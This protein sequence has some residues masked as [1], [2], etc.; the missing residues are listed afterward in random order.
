LTDAVPL[1][2]DGV[3]E[4]ADAVICTSPDS[5]LNTDFQNNSPHPGNIEAESLL[6]DESSE[7]LMANANSEVKFC[8]TKET[9]YRK[10]KRLL[11]YL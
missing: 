11:F 7:I 9:L 1:S 2:I 4:H 3:E 5:G 10:L 6:A 8:S